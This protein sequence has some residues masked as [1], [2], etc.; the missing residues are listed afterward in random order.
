MLT[1]REFDKYCKN[2]FDV[3]EYPAV[4]YKIASDF[5]GENDSNSNVRELHENFLKS[6]I[7]EELYQMQNADG[8]WGR[9]FSK[10]YSAKDKFPTTM[11]ALERCLYIGLKLDDRDILIAALDYLEE[12]LQGTNREKLYN[13]NERA[14]PWQMADI[15]TMVER[16]KPYNSLCDRLWGEWFYI[17][18]QAFADG[19]YSYER[20][21]SAQHEVLWTREK[22]LVPLP[23][24][25]LLGRRKDMPEKLENDMLHYFGG[26]AYENG[27]FWDKAPMRLPETFIGDKTRRWFHAIK[28]INQFRNSSEY[29]S[30]TVEWLINNRNSDG[31]W[32][33]G[34]QTK[35]PWGYFGYFSTNRNYKHNKVVDCTME[36]LSV[37]D[38]YLKNN[39]E[40]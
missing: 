18:S 6:D 12:F 24:T 33:Y 37:F 35:D 1:K 11:V 23:V 8:N 21:K 2:L 32:D 3:C 40:E 25:F 17:A 20:D 39:G 28:Y 14:V 10:D 22:R 38:T 36:V 4:K 13:K 27:Y 30:E 5:L 31:L 19:E 34:T 29:L 26:H 7:V 16:I 15:A 9:L